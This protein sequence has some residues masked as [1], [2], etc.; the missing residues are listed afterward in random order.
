MEAYGYSVGILLLDVKVPL[1]P[2]DA[3]N[4]RSFEYPVMY[5]AVPGL[6]WEHCGGDA[7]GLV[8]KAVAAAKAL[9]EQGVK[10]IAGNAGAML[11]FQD[12]VSAAIDLP[13]CL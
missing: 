9:D 3:G 1:I 7:N 6:D 13:V 4:S 5:R 8:E 12:A 11:R 2:G 10:A